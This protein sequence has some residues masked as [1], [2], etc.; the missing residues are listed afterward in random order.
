MA[1]RRML[2]KTITENDNFVALPAA[3][4]ALYMHLTM[5]ADDDGF[6][7]QVSTAMFRAHAKKKDLEALV[8]ARYLL[9]FENGVMVI[10]HWR[11]ANALRKDRHAPTV[12]QEELQRLTLKDN[13][14]YTMASKCDSSDADVATTRQ[15]DG[16]QTATQYRLGKDS[17]GKVRLGKDINESSVC[18]A[19]AP[20]REE[21]DKP[22]PDRWDEFW[23][24]Y[25]RKSGGDIR[26]AC[27]E[28]IA[29]IDH[30]LDPEILISAA[31]ALAKRTT[32][33]TFRYL[34]SAE[35]WLRNKGW[36]ENPEA[37]QST[38]TNNIFLQMYEEEYGG[39]SQ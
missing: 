16:N 22:D 29:V 19:H 7:N 32:R 31:K 14:A 9:R 35:K 5:S 13:G 38:E 33:E 8:A 28:Y 24:A 20:A 2:A 23:A 6:C 18:T 34:P 17:V 1:D 37:S 11:M 27:M 26:E 21:S 39:D 10:K 3:A 15:P 30:G 36:L 25:P 4:Q 12:Y